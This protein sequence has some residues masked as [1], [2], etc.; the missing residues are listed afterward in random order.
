MNS[1]HYLL[2]IWIVAFIASLGSLFFSDV[3]GYPPCVLCWYQRIAMYPLVVILPWGLFPFNRLV[4]K[5]SIAL[6]LF[7]WFIALYHNLLYYKILPEYHSPCVKGISC[8]SVQL[9]WLG[10]ITI[11]LLSLIAFSLILIASYL[12]LKRPSYDE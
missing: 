1:W 2:A 4:L 11:P 12:V 5:M 10:F 3:M 9:Q 6:P 8:T 7:G